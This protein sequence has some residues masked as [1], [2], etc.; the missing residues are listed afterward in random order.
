M[1]TIS[2]LTLAVFTTL[3]HMA[4]VAPTGTDEATGLTQDAIEQDGDFT[5]GMTEADEVTPASVAAAK[6]RLKDF[7]EVPALTDEE[8]AEIL[9]KYAKVQHSGI[10]EPLY[11]K[12]ILYY[13]TNFERIPNK[14]YL[15][16]IDFRAH[17][18]NRRYYILDMEGGP[19]TSYPTS[20]GKKSDPNDDGLA[21]LFSNVNGSNMSS[22]GYYLTAETYIGGNGRSLR[23]DGLSRTNSNARERLVVIHGANYVSDGRPK[24]GLSLGCPAFDHAVAQGIIDRLQQGSLIYAMN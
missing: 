15:S 6:D 3:S 18:K 12:A 4:C 1:R 24:Q 9:A 2:I 10:R 21:T 17:S 13:H 5:D 16:I 20:H 22:V 11:E 7:E 14:R 8:K 19:M 23:L